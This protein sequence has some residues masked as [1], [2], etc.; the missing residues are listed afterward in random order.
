MPRILFATFG[1]LGDLHPYLALARESL[2][3]GHQPTIATFDLYRDAVQAEGIG[4]APMR[5]GLSEFGDKTTVTQA[6]LSAR[7]G[8]EYLVRHMFAPHIRASYED[9]DR[10]AQ[11]C[12]LL[13]THP[14]A[15]AGPMIAQLRGLPWASTVLSPLS[16]MSCIDPPVFPGAEWMRSLRRIGVGPYR[17]LFALA[18]HIAGKWEK[19]VHALRAEL[20]IP[21]RQLAQFEGQ[22]APRL[23]LALFSAVLAAP[24]A[25]WPANTVACGFPRYDGNPPDAATRARLDAFLRAGKAPLV[26]ALGSSAVTVAGAFW[27]HAITAAGALKQRAILLTGMPPDQFGE[28]PP[29]IATF[30]YL[31]YSAV[32][33]HAMAIVHQGGIGT[34]A[35]AF[36]AGRPQLI[37]PVAF[38]QPD[39]AMRAAALGVA[40]VLPFE[41]ITAARLTRQLS[42]LLDDPDRAACADTVGAV[43]R[44]ENGAAAACDELEKLLP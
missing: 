30:E 11:D 5:P 34:L 20:G 18:K 44:A 9:L 32:F 31:P 28:L 23:N 7:N 25:D 4:F 1:S 42:A 2:R 39:N 22:Y 27:R 14:L 3:R 38:D 17:L 36:A 13:V 41:N 19:P 6:L 8:P 43:V 24:Q 29:S 35:Q 37:V 21:T 33:P 40:R 15:F 16:L 26:F 12:D 10:A